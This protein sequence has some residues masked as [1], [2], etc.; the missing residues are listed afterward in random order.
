MGVIITNEN[1]TLADKKRGSSYA[2]KL[3]WACTPWSSARKVSATP[4]PTSS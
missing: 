2:V 1:V 4:T 3:A